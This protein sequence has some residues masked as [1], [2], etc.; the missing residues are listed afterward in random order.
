M[1]RRITYLIFTIVLL[2]AP[3]LAEAASFT[4][5]P[6]TGTYNSGCNFS[7]K[8][9]LDSAGAKVDS[10]EAVLLFDNGKITPA[11]AAVSQGTLFPT[12][13]PV[14]TTSAGKV[15]ISGIS[16]PGNPFT[17]SGLF[18]TVNFTVRP[19][20]AAG[21][22]TIKFDFDPNDR[23]K[24]TDSNIVES[25][26]IAEL[27]SSVGDGSYNVGTGPG[28]NGAAA[29]QPVGGSGSATLTTQTLSPNGVNP[30]FSIPTLLI[31]GAAFF[32]ILIGIVLALAL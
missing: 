1:I 14:T 31:G 8:I 12:Y 28:C 30:G 22:F 3:T 5:S 27:L 17:G 32:L 24:T 7:V 11:S 25:T 9:N 20:T 2:A 29:T 13:V 19:G 16:N 10:A 26:T 23:A 18:A 21:P 15:V 6:A 4:L